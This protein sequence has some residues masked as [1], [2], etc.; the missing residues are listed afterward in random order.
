MSRSNGRTDLSRYRPTMIKHAVTHQSPML[1][2]TA[3]LSRTSERSRSISSADRDVFASTCTCASTW[4]RSVPRPCAELTA[5][6]AMSAA[7]NR[8]Y[9]GNLDVNFTQAELEEECRR[10]GQT[11]SVWVARNPPGFAFVV[12]AP[13]HAHAQCC[14]DPLP[15]GPRRLTSARLS[16]EF[17]D[18]RGAE[19]ACRALN[20]VKLGSQ[21]VRVE[22]SKNKVTM[23]QWASQPSAAPRHPAATS[24]TPHS[25]LRRR[26]IW[27]LQRLRAAG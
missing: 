8:L 2:R 10:F 4:P 26:G 22:F 19:G 1:Q 25:L 20:D 14:A 24:S 6:A 11:T 9:F 27:S 13:R 5:P 12:R 23:Q 17:A 7:T 15:V 18:I 3:K 16:Q 21:H